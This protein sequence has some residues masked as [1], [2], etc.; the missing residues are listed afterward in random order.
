MPEDRTREMKDLKGIRQWEVWQ[1][2]TC[3]PQHTVAWQPTRGRG[4]GR[5]RAGFTNTP[6]FALQSTVLTS[7]VTCTLCIVAFLASQTFWGRKVAPF[8]FNNFEN[9]PFCYS[10]SQNF[11][12]KILRSPFLSD[13][14][15]FSFFLYTR[16]FF[17]QFFCPPKVFRDRGGCSVIVNI[18]DGSFSSW[19]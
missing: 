17:T 15:F 7:C 2:V 4:I 6:L 1:G 8:V 10:A 3:N 12:P 13:P 19:F 11:P 16:I 9:G 5:D 14:R 18:R